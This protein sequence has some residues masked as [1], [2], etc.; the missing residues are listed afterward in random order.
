MK[1][2]LATILLMAAVASPAFA[3]NHKPKTSHHRIS[4][5][6]KAPKNYKTHFHRQ[7]QKHHHPA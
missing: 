1:K 4:H 3:S 5:R 2:L 6:Y 7:K